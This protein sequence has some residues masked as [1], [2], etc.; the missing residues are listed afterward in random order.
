MPE[1][2]LSRPGG[3]NFR[4]RKGGGPSVPA[5]PSLLTATAAGPTSIDLTWQDNSADE[6]LFALDV[7]L[8]G[9]TW[10]AAAFPAANATGHTHAGL[11][12]ETLYYY[13]I[14]A[15]NDAGSSAYSNTASA[16][17]EATPADARTLIDPATDMTWLGMARI[18]AV[19]TS[20]PDGPGTTAFTGAPLAI[21]YVGG[22]RRILTATFA[23]T[24]ATTGREFGDLV[25]Y[26]LPVGTSLYTGSDTTA[27]TALTETRRWADWTLVQDTPSWQDTASGVRIGGLYWDEARGVLWY[28]AYGYYSGVNRPVLGATQLLD[29][30]TTGSYRAVGTRYGPWW[31]RSNTAGS[32]TDLYWKSACN[33]VVPVPS[34]AQ[35]DLGGRKCIVGAGV[36]AVGGQ[37]HLGPGFH[38]IA[39]FP[40]LSDPA[41]TTIPLGLRLADYTNESPES[42]SSC[43]RDG[44]YDVVLPPPG[45]PGVEYTAGAAS[46]LHDPSGGLGYWQMSLDQINSFAW[47]DT[48]TKHGIVLFGRAAGGYTWYGLNPLAADK[49]SDG[50]SRTDPTRPDPDSNGYGAAGWAGVIRVFDPDHVREVGR[51]ERSPYSDGMRPASVTPWGDVAANIPPN[52]LKADGAAEARPISSQVANAAAWD[53]AAQQL[54]WLQPSS[55]TAAGGPPT[56]QV[57]SIGGG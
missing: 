11:E 7:S 39:D 10:G 42:P 33:W 50:V 4:I 36:G 3:E 24:S 22:E 32:T 20:V 26:A 51:G 49:S 19:G 29:T 57:F 23:P 53:A 2:R 15:N 47:V 35:A 40:P 43:R 45:T 31:Y 18:P 56:V 34:Y 38:A 9:T 5:A 54:V 46:G 55:A 44:D 14:K 8:D 13:R 37:G 6:N 41:D 48:G 1:L 52:K 21:R 27:A 12:P 25:E 30:V 16:T 28:T 17:T